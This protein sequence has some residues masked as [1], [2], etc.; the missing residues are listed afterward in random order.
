[1]AQLVYGCLQGPF[2]CTAIRSCDFFLSKETIQGDY[3]DAVFVVR[4]AEYKIQTGE[5]KIGIGM[6][7][8]RVFSAAKRCRY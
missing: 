8:T 5:G 2:N 7:A 1:M 3:S 6:A 4:E